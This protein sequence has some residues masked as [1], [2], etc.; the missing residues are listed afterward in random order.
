MTVDTLR[1][2][3]LGAYGYQAAATVH[4]DALA[5]EGILFE[6]VIVQLGLKLNF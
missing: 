5:R 2:D 6:N 3:R 1:A 4:M